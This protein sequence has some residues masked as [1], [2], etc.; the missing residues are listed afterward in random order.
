M[1]MVDRDVCKLC[2]ENGHE[3]ERVSHETGNGKFCPCCDRNDVTTFHDIKEEKDFEFPE[4][5]E[6]PSEFS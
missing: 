1:T 5:G 3:V 6:G 4:G 2:E